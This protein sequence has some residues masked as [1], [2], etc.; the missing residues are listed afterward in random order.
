MCLST[1]SKT[2]G[3]LDRTTVVAWKVFKK[4]NNT[5]N[6]LWRY[7][8]GYKTGTWIKSVRVPV[9]YGTPDCFTYNSGFHAILSRRDARNLK[10]SMYLDAGESYVVRKVR[11]RGPKTFGTQNFG[12][13]DCPCVVGDEMF[14]S[15][16]TKG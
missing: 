6:S 3:Y 1:V 16:S 9:N 2:T 5:M 8:C 13:G 7:G 4:I 12:I 14:I 15:K 11:L 10:N